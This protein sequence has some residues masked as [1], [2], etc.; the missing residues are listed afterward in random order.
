MQYKRIKNLRGPVVVLTFDICSSSDVIEDLHSTAQLSRYTHLIGE[1]KRYLAKAQAKLL[2][3]PYKFTG[4]GWILLFPVDST[5]GQALLRFMRGLSQFFR[6]EFRKLARHLDTLPKITGITFGADVGE[7]WHMTVYG[8]DE[9]VG[10]PINIACRL[11]GAI[12]DRD[13]KPAYKALV[14]R[15]VFNNYLSPATGF[16]KKGVRRRLRN[17]RDNREFRCVLIRLL[18]V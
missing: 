8:R 12:K 18:P 13:R 2:F 15:S 9:Y 16:H 10:R 11:Q 3:D 14:T 4:D 5:S 6:R 1:V 17:I 7:L